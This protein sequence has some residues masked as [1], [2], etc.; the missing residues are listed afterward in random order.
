MATA[1]GHQREMAHQ[2]AVRRSGSGRPRP[3]PRPG[4]PGDPA[5]PLDPGPRSGGPAL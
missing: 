5:G 2:P 3:A 4:R 1:R